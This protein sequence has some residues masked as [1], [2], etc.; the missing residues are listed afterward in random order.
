[1][2]VLSLDE[3]RHRTSV[4]WRRYPPEV[5][6]LWVAEMDVPLA[7][8]VARALEKA[9]ALG[10]TGYAHGS[11]YASALA[12]YTGRRWG[13]RFDPATTSLVADVMRGIVEVLFVITEPGST[14]VVNPPVYPPFYPFLVHAGRGL[15]TVPLGPDHR[16]D[17]AALEAVFAAQRPAAYLLCSPH[18]PTGTVHTRAELSTVASLAAQ[19]GVRV[20]VD[21]IH[22]PI[23]YPDAT[24]TPYLSLPGTENAVALWSASKAWN[25]AGLK[26]AV[27]VPGTEAAFDLAMLPEEVSHGPSHLGVISHSAALRDGGEWF[28]AL[29]AGLD[30]N[31]RL[32]AALVAGHLPEVRYRQPEGTFF[33][34][35]DCG[36]LGLGPDPAAAFL[37][38]G[39]VALVPGLEFG[40]GGDSYVRLNL[41]TSPE[42]LAEAVR[43]MASVL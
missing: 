18:N 7:A 34:W 10:D 12:E 33:A 27:A 24:F 19:Y 28:E 41:A 26:A 5:L 15:A 13:W 21:E 32:M 9:I 31:R 8:P 17:L 36:A 14:V 3:L 40:T 22:A 29:L 4:K 39:R 2:L 30:E 37:A 16:L 11:G 20:V 1:L 35:L 42:I 38:R 6:P 25:L 23:V 43:R